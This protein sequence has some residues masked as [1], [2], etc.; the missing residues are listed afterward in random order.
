MKVKTLLVGIGASAVLLSLAVFGYWYFVVREEVLYPNGTNK[1]ASDLVLPTNALLV[2]RNILHGG[3]AGYSEGYSVICNNGNV[4]LGDFRNAQ[5][6]KTLSAAE[7]STVK[8]DLGNKSISLKSVSKSDGQ[9]ILDHCNDCVTG[10][11]GAFEYRGS[12]KRSAP[13]SDLEIETVMTSLQPIFTAPKLSREASSYTIEVG[14]GGALKPWLS[15]SGPLISIFLEEMMNVERKS[16]WGGSF[17]FDLSK[18]SE[19]ENSYLKNE[20]KTEAEKY[21][22]LPNKLNGYFRIEYV[23]DYTGKAMRLTAWF[24]TAHS[25]KE[26]AEALKMS[27]SD[28]LKSAEVKM[29]KNILG[30]DL[31]LTKFAALRRYDYSELRDDISFYFLNSVKVMQSGYLSLRER[32]IINQASSLQDLCSQKVEK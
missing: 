25:A 20:F 5:Y 19:S 28:F 16:D 32:Y 6:L 4:F 2:N 18:I 9:G 7:I 12:D 1:S 17:N 14:L 10:S 21:Y 8:S 22:Y 27:E 11:E 15:K 30:G 3:F 24:T 26:V 29:K 23:P 31:D 13:R